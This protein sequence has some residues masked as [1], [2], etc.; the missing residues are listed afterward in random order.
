M[1]I[2]SICLGQ[3]I[4]TDSEYMCEYIYVL[5]SFTANPYLSAQDLHTLECFIVRLS[6]NYASV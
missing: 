6:C 3:R 4:C 2:L 1:D 5:D